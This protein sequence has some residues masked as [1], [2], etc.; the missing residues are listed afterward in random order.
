M[1]GARS[2]AI[3]EKLRENFEC[4]RCDNGTQVIKDLRTSRR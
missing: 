3:A 1:T 2:S 4:L